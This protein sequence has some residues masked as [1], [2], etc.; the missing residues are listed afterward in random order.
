M[1]RRS[2][3]FLVLSIFALAASGCDP[4]AVAR[5][6]LDEGT[7]QEVADVSTYTHDGHRGQVADPDNRDPAWIADGACGA[8]QSFN[9]TQLTIA[10]ATEAL[11]PENVT[12]EARVRAD[13]APGAY[14]YI[15]AK[16]FKP[17]KYAS[18]AL[19]TGPER[20]VNFYVTTA[21]GNFTLSPTAPI[22]IWD[23]EWHHV[24]GTYDGSSVRLYVDGVEVGSGTPK[25]GAIDYD[26]GARDEVRIGAFSPI[27]YGFVGDIDEVTIYDYAMNA[28]EVANAA[29]TCASEAS[30]PVATP[31]DVSRQ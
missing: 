5:W 22:T 31:S 2:E 9:G 19:Y 4:Q 6:S 28:L 20:G 27:C 8:A 24:A 16:G 11:E 25:T 26:L 18:Y 7:G 21:N 12:V 13:T 29:S 17:C 23:G 3:V 1:S 30:Q 15:A 14:T 10:E